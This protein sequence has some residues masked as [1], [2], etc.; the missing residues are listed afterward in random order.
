MPLNHNADKDRW[1]T[2]AHEMCF[3]NERDMLETF[4]ETMSIAEIANRLGVGTATINRRLNLCGIEKRSRGGDNTKARLSVLLYHIDQRTVMAM[5]GNEFAATFGI[6]KSRV[7]K[8]KRWKCNNN[9]IGMMLNAKGTTEYGTYLMGRTHEHMHYKP[10]SWLGEVQHTEQASLDASAR[11]ESSLS[12]ILS[13]ALG[14]G[15]DGDP[16]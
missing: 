15:R 14:N 11:D 10:N 3:R 16:R 1:D 8:Y 7:Y 13:D 5:P 12:S 4:Y 2:L 9:P 6:S